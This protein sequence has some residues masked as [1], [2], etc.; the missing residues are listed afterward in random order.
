MEWGRFFTE[1][2]TLPRRTLALPPTGRG[3]EA[4]LGTAAPRS[5]VGESSEPGC[6]SATPVKALVRRFDRAALR[7]R[8][9]GL[10][11]KASSSTSC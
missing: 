2:I 6:N 4:P 3:P 9:V 7:V 10:D 8:V 5:A 11:G 1:L